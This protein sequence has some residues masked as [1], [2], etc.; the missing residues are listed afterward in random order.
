MGS[1]RSVALM[2]AVGLIAAAATAK[3]ADNVVLMDESSSMSGEQEWMKST[4]PILD[5][6]LGAAGVTDNRYGL[7]GFGASAAPAPDHVRSFVVGGGQFGS[8]ADYVAASAGLVSNGSYEDGWAAID[9][10]NSYDFRSGAVRNYILVSDEDRDSSRD[11]F[12][13]T[14]DSVL[15]SLTSTKTL[16]NAVVSARFECGDGSRAIGVIGTMGYKADG[17]GGFVK[18]SGASWSG[19]DN[20]HT[21]EDYVEMAWKTGGG[22]WDLSLLRAGGLTAQ[23]FT[24]AFIDGKVTEIVIQPPIPEPSTYALMVMGLGALGI[25]ARRRREA[26]R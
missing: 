6:A 19:I 5:T 4:I 2:G 1:L 24:A 21:F 14:F 18:C 13:G 11:G 7:I 15:A 25:A 8:A 20:G 17:A 26:A 16:L 12:A 10:A 9:L 3:T 22:A 23:S